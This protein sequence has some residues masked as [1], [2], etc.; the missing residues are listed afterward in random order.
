VEEQIGGVEEKWFVV[1]KD[2]GTNKVFVAPGTDHPALY[3]D[4]LE[5]F[6]TDFN[7]I[8]PCPLQQV[9]R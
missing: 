4:S 9:G 2:M 8:G 6:A 5:I 1:G 3:T 7:W